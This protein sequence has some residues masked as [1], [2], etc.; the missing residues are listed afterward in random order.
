MK[1]LLPACLFLIILSSCK[2]DLTCSCETTSSSTGTQYGYDY[3][4]DGW[5][6]N[7][8]QTSSPINNEEYSYTE[9]VNYTNTT[10]QIASGNCPEEYSYSEDF[11]NTYNTGLIDYY[12]GNIIIAGS[13]GQYTTKKTCILE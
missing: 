4:W 1:H 13:V 3:F 5:T 9:E 6:E 8:T 11:D 10:T 7:Y 2:K 12:S